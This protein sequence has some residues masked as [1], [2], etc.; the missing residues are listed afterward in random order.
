MKPKNNEA[1]TSLAAA[2]KELEGLVGELESGETDLEE[3]ISKF[4]RGLKLAKWLK[5]R[6][7]KIENEIETIKSQTSK[8]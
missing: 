3:S 4:R 1:K 8:P 2:F 5:N 6:L 7:R